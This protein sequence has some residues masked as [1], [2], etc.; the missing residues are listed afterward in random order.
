MPFE[1]CDQWISKLNQE[2]HWRRLEEE[3]EILAFEEIAQD[4]AEI[5][6]FICDAMKKC[7]V[8]NQQEKADSAFQTKKAIIAKN[9]CGWKKKLNFKIMMD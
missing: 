7:N 9:C 6:H 2:K 1:M 3:I 5:V 8:T 4:E